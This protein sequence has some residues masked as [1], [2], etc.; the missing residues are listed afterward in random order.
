MLQVQ[1]REKGRRQIVPG[2][3]EQVSLATK[4]P[5]YSHHFP[6]W[7]RPSRYVQRK[8]I[9]EITIRT[10]PEKVMMTLIIS[11]RSTMEKM[12]HDGPW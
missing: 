2:E 6:F 12:A 11:K 7:P 8:S 10:G 3:D 9:P 1:G 4:Q 5:W